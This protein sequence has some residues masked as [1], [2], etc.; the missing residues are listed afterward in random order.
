M[1]GQIVE[2]TDP[3]HWLNKHRGFLEVRHD[4]EKLG[5]VPLDD[6]AAIIISVPGCS[7]STN[8]LDHLAQRNVP[9]VTC[10]QNYLPSTWTLPVQGYNRQFQVMRAQATLS[11]PKRKRA[12]QTIVKAK[13]TN[14][15]EV[16]SR[17]GKSDVRLKRLA[18][19]VRSGDPDNCEAQAA[20]A[21]WQELFG[22]DF[23]RNRDAPGLNVVLN[24]AYTVVRAGVARGLV[25]A[26]LHPSF[27]LHH[28]NP[29]N[30]LNLVDDVM[31]PFR[32]IADYLIYKKNYDDIGDLNVEIKSDLAS[33][34]T[35]SLPVA[36]EISPLSQVAVRV[37]RSLAAYYMGEADTL[38]MPVLPDPLEIAA[39]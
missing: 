17:A 1:V 10:G 34:M 36:G 24:Y 33:L 6:I 20:R 26:G 16:L 4:G 35:L 22:S 25:G 37:S 2:I 27:S 39:L 18:D 7:V 12:W 14:Q 9:V 5:Q 15:A 32:P 21:Y 3:G 23:R 30:P 29:Q 31:E 13:I 19:N 28:K 11:E 8:L 38:L